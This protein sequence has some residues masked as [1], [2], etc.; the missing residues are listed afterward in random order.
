MDF[1]CVFKPTEILKKLERKLDSLMSII[2]AFFSFALRYLI[3]TVQLGS[4]VMTAAVLCRDDAITL[5]LLIFLIQ[6][7]VHSGVQC[8]TFDETS[9]FW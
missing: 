3:I 9:V 4:V 1:P 2:S 7:Q 6:R 5:M 8:P